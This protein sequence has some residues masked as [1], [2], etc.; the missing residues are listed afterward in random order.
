MRHNGLCGLVPR[1]RV[2]GVYLRDVACDFACDVAA[3]PQHSVPTYIARDALCVVREKY[4]VHG[5]TDY[6]PPP[7]PGPRPRA[8][9]PRARGPSRAAGAAASSLVSHTSL[10]ATH[11]L[12]LC[13]VCVYT[14]TQHG[15]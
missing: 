11:P 10:G 7:A 6:A 1:I 9:G 13:L 2:C 3:S 4:S 5:F 15:R 12:F 14:L 8:C